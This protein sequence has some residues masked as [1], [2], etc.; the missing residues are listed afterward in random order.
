MVWVPNSWRTPVYLFALWKLGAIVVPF[1][2][3]MNPESVERILSSV[4]ARG[5]IAGYDERPVWAKVADV[6]DWWEPHSNA[7]AEHPR[8]RVDLTGR[9]IRHNVFHLGYDRTAERVHDHSRQP[10]LAG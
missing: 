10:V 7:G 8:Q 9:R 2:R 4:N 1:D 6:I 5:V 3:E